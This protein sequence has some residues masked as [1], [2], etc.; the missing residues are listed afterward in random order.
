MTSAS[1]RII[2]LTPDML[3]PLEREFGPAYDASSSRVLFA[4]RA[5]AQRINDDVNGRLARFG[6]NSA[7]YNYIVTLYASKDYSLTQNRIRQ[8]VHTTYASVTQMVRSL[9][10][11]GLVK[12]V[13]NPA[14]GRSVIVTLTPKGVKLARRA[15][16]ANHRVLERKLKNLSLAQRE[17]LI[18]LLL[19]VIDGFDEADL[20]VP[21]SIPSLV[22]FERSEAQRRT[23]KA[24]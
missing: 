2:E 15:I 24:G 5:V 11:A 19:A 6:L 14:D 9:E 17:N 10:D 7:S 8:I 16:P 1:K 12:R 18:G 22:R 21:R 13:K 20:A 23:K 3:E 4:I